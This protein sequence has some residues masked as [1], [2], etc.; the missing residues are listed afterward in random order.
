MASKK[1]KY[2]WQRNHREYMR[3]KA[4]YHSLK[5][6]LAWREIL[7]GLGLD[8]CKQCGYDKCFHAIEYH[9]TDASEKMETASITFTKNPTEERVAI[10]KASVENGTIRPLCA[11]CHREEHF[12][13]GWIGRRKNWKGKE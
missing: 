5:N 11:N 7:R 10:F 8:R 2:T 4:S 9:H 1:Q 13:L 12:R 6:R 3:D